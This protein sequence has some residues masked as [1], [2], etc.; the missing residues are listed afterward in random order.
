MKEN[1]FKVF[2]LFSFLMASC[3]Y[4][5]NTMTPTIEIHE[6]ITQTVELTKVK[7]IVV[8]T[9]QEVILPF[10]TPTKFPEN[11]IDDPKGFITTLLR[12]NGNCDAPCILGISPGSAQYISTNTFFKYFKSLNAPVDLSLYD[13]GVNTFSTDHSEL[14]NIKI[15]ENNQIFQIYFSD[16]ITESGFINMLHLAAKS[17]NI[18]LDNNSVKYTFDNPYYNEFFSYYSVQNIMKIFGQPSQILVAP[19]DD[20]FKQ[21]PYYTFSIILI[22]PEQGFLIQYISLHVNEGD[23]YYGCPSKSVFDIM[24]WQPKNDESIMMVIKNF[25]GGE[26]INPLNFSW[27]KDIQNV[28]GLRVKEFYEKY[29]NESNECIESPKKIWFPPEK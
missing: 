15:K 5:K 3:S 9:L 6:L 2:L 20:P 23:N 27:F 1:K 11:S 4:S 18:N 28:T 22:Y 16:L 29:R 10:A 21:I 24:A 17:I 7:T 8:P 14:L 25:D 19:L 13:Y 12:T 26:G